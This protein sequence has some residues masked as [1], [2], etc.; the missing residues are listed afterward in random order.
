MAR[1][2]AADWYVPSYYRFFG[3]ST[4]AH[5]DYTEIGGSAADYA[6]TTF[7]HWVPSYTSPAL[8][9]AFAA[10]AAAPDADEARMLGPG[11]T[12][13]NR[14]TTIT[15]QAYL[16]ISVT[17]AAVRDALVVSGVLADPAA[18]RQYG[19][20]V[21]WPLIID[22]FYSTGRSV[23]G[24]AFNALVRECPPDVVRSQGS[25]AVCF[26]NIMS[27]HSYMYGINEKTPPL[28]NATLQTCLSPRGA[29]TPRAAGPIP[30]P[31]SSCILRR[32]RGRAWAPT[33]RDRNR[34]KHFIFTTQS[35]VR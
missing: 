24:Y 26:C 31:P 1:L 9:A 16:V 23:E 7:T 4:M 11:E 25:P 19:R 8:E 21:A 10:W 22:A 33:A 5:D 20:P 27:A 12:F 32:S 30:S 28:G 34:K 2:V 14:T 35:L 18:P 17:M 3:F 6:S 29:A 13:E 15:R